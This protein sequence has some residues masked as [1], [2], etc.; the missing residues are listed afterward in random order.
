MPAVFAIIFTGL[1][2]L[3]IGSGYQQNEFKKEIIRF[4]ARCTKMGGLT[5]QAYKTGIQ[6]VGC[7]KDGMELEN[8]E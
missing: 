6:W 4:E 3:L 7:Y 5:L 8:E 2:A 1:F